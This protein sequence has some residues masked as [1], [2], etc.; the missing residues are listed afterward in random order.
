MICKELC[1]LKDIPF[2]EFLE[3]KGGTYCDHC[4]QNGEK[5]VAKD[6]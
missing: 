4:M 6:G 1:N 3:E 2:N 5:E